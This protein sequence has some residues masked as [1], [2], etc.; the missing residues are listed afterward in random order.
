MGIEGEEVITIV[1]WS[2]EALKRAF[3]CL[4]YAASK[5]MM[6]AFEASECDGLYHLY[7]KH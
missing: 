1:D 3:Y 5:T 4:P 2:Y 6:L 7:L